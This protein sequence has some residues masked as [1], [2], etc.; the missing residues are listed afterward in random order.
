MSGTVASAP[1][2]ADATI[3]NDAVAWDE[4]QPPKAGESP[5]RLADIEVVDE[6]AVDLEHLQYSSDEK[7][8]LL[9]IF[10]IFDADNSGD[11]TAAEVLHTCKKL[12]MFGSSG[13]GDGS[14]AGAWYDRRSHLA[15]RPREL[16]R[17]WMS[18]SD[19]EPK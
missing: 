4:F 5:G 3:I 16:I 1:D 12:G 19:T 15:R 2:K 6:V 14:G 9:D 17:T 18:I 13:S 11:V 7:R 10:S 8:D